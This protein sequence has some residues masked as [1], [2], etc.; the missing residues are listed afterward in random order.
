MP[1]FP[2]EI[3]REIFLQLSDQQMKRTDSSDP[4]TFMRIDE[5]DWHD[6]LDAQT[7][8]F[9][10]LT[11][12]KFLQP[13]AEEF[14]FAGVYLATQ[15]SYEQFCT[16]ITSER[17][18][19]RGLLGSLI[20]AIHFLQISFEGELESGAFLALRRGCSKLSLMH[21]EYCG[22]FDSDKFL[23]FVEPWSATLQTFILT[24]RPGFGNATSYPIP[25]FDNAT[26]LHLTFPMDITHP[27]TLRVKRLSILGRWFYL[28]LREI[29][30]PSLQWL[31]I[32]AFGHLGFGIHSLTY[33]VEF[34]KRHSET[35]IGLDIVGPLHIERPPQTTP[36]FV[37][38][39]LETLILPEIF[40]LLDASL[41]R[42]EQNQQLHTLMVHSGK[43][44]GA[45]L[46]KFIQNI[47]PKTLPQLKR[48]VLIVQGKNE[49]Y[50][51]QAKEVLA[52]LSHEFLPHVALECYYDM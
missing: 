19:G 41:L 25:T 28:D 7:A 10:M 1:V 51:G 39:K 14:L 3:W 21:F 8:C 31:R 42:L 47:E 40:Q 5:V 45:S 34:L 18:D 33:L 6:A 23:K 38:P 27:V 46:E 15:D 12:C 24:Q 16:R 17:Q 50:N 49:E 32:E 29:T 26:S 48:F 35:L 11:V 52:A 44:D 30:C 37:L 4:L 43:L 20:R 2:V 9:H 36:L 22:G 13:L